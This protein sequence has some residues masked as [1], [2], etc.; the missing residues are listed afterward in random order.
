[1]MKKF[2]LLLVIIFSLFSLTICMSSS[3]VQADG[4]DIPIEL[5]IDDNI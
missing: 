1:M 5:L 2:V 3:V 4:H